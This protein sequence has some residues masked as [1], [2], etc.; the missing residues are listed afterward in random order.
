M[1]TISV[2]YDC[3][4]EDRA[5]LEAVRRVYS[6]AVRTA[7]ANAVGT[8][9]APLRQKELRDLVKARLAGGAVD[10]WSLH[11]ATLEGMDLRKARP[12]GRMVFGSR[13]GLERRRKGLVGRDE[14]RAMR[15]RPF[16]SR[17]DRTFLGNRHFRLAPDGRSCAFRMYGREAVLDLAAMRGNAGAVLRQAAALAAAKRIN[18]TFRLDAEKLHVTVDPSELP[19]HPER[20]RPAASVPGR[21]LGID[22]NP[23]WIGMAVVENVGDATSLAETELLD[24]QLTRLDLPAGAPAELVRETLAAVA[25]R[26]IRLCRKWGVGTIAVEKGLGRLRSSGRNRS[27]NR[28]LNHWAREVFIAMLRRKGGLAGIGV[29]EAWGGYGTTVG[30]LAFEAP[31]ACASA[32]EIARRGLAASRGE[33]DVL[34]GLDGGWLA[35]RRKDLPP[36]AESGSWRDVHQ[37]IKAAGLG[38]RRPHPEFPPGPDARPGRTSCGHAVVRLRHRRRPGLLFRP[39]RQARTGAG[40]PSD[41]GHSIATRNAATSN[42]G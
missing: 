38:Y 12:D 11:C 3:S 10:A 21:A 22:L 37:A 32:A 33:K 31:D 20:R 17:G 4:D 18:V 27:L 15:L 30:N 19:A 35:S 40:S 26:A 14:W 23:S 16:C 41:R 42:D 5:F 36:P 34:P 9:G 2:P 7:Y 24:H 29:V 6:A 25:D 39:T 1:Q 28:L 8:D 13:A